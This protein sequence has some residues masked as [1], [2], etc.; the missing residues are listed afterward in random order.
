MQQYCRPNFLPRI[1]SGIFTAHKKINMK[2]I[3][4]IIA[5]AFLPV[6]SANAQIIKLNMPKGTGYEVATATT[7]TSKASVMGQDFESGTDISI[8]ETVKIKDT[9]AGE[10]DLVRTTNKIVAKVQGMGQ[11]TAYDS[12]KKDNDGTMA[13]TFDKMIGRQKNATVDTYGKIIKQDKNAEESEAIAMMGMASGEGIPFLSNN[14]IGR[15]VKPGTT[16]YDSTATTG[17]KIT[18]FTVGNYTVQDINAGTATIVFI[19]TTKLSGT[20]EQM[21]QEMAMTS[22]STVNSQFEVDM[23]TGLIK[24]ST[25]TTEGTMNIEA[26]GMSIPAVTKTIVTMSAKQQ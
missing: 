10:T 24:K 25:E 1:F 21:G 3:K 20:I 14:F 16:W 4:L 22:T 15:E 13:E 19:G 11:A 7:I 23:A 17:D 18:S 8:T 2:L 12:D 9:R 26:G 6:C 5:L